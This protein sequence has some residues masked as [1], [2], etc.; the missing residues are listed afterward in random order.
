MDDIDFS[1]ISAL[2]VEDD[3]GGVALI[4]SL[5]R[6]MGIKAYVDSSGLN[7]LE[8][9]REMN[10]APDI[11]FLDLNLPRK[12]GFDILRELRADEKFKDARVI[13]MTALDSHTA[14]RKC[15]EAGFNG[16]IPKPLGRQRLADQIQRILRGEPVWDT[17]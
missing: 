5:L 10:P 4:S 13:A 14:L 12:T 7:T 17:E 16:Y 8:V 15:K 1:T 3:P 2:A 6:R 11:I 9:V